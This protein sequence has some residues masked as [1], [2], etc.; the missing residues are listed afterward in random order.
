MEI[1]TNEIKILPYID[2]NEELRVE[3]VSKDLDLFV[4]LS[5]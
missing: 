2:E 3:E 1:N 4:S 5:Y